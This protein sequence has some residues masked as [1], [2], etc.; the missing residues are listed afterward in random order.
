MSKV[1]KRDG[2][3]GKMHGDTP[4]ERSYMSRVIFRSDVS[5]PG[6]AKDLH[7]RR[8]DMRQSRTRFCLEQRGGLPVLMPV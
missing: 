8:S 7:D 2:R 1:K 3:V 6:F 5:S 4:G